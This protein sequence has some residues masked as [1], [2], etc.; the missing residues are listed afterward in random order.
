MKKYVEKYFWDFILCLFISAG[1]AENIFAG[2]EMTD[3][4]SGNIFAVAGV[5]AV[6]TVLL[7]CGYYNRM[8]VVIAMTA[9][10]VALIA[11][12]VILQ[13][14]GVFSAP[15]TIDGNP[16]LFWIIVISTSC[17]VF[18]AARTRAG[19]VVL[20]LAGTAMTAAFDIL[21]YS[22]CRWGYC[23]F[24]WGVFILFL[25]RVYCISHMYSEREITALNMY[26]AQSV[27][28]GT[29]VLLLASGAYYGIIKP[30]SPPADKLNLTQE[31]LSM[32]I[33]YEIGVASTRTLY[34]DN[35][36]TTAEN[37]KQQN[38]NN[39]N[40]DENSQKQNEQKKEETVP[41]QD[42][43]TALAVTFKHNLKM[44]WIAAASVLMML[45]LAFIIKFI[46]RKKWYNNLLRETKEDSAMELYNYFLK[47]LVK[48]GFRRPDGL[49]LLEYA[50][51]L[52][53]KLEKFSTGQANILSLTQIYTRILY[54]CQKISEDEW[55][56]FN[57]FY[58]EFYRN[59]KNEMGNFKYLVHFFTI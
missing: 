3:P 56:L 29:M 48:I 40:Y 7:F 5:V 41:G 35:P 44:I 6:V 19:L 43:I 10:T 28:A 1:L 31:L 51:G 21:E 23:A 18:W 25:Y 11:V 33:L 8:T 14:R 53:D 52:Q 42:P 38:T 55:E 39:E 49:T 12:I 37:G 34:S 9:Q 50:S 22:V 2:Y 30:M 58:K 57:D 27:I 45:V 26:F 24:V 15:Y 16:M 4:W 13:Q 32:D 36:V 54:G 46:L 59:L 17:V 47:Q 20:F